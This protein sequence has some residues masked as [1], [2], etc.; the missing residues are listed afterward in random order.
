MLF[1]SVYVRLCPA[2][3]IRTEIY[4]NLVR[5]IVLNHCGVSNAIYYSSCFPQPYGI[6]K[7]SEGSVQID[8]S[9]AAVDFANFNQA[10]QFTVDQQKHRRDVYPWQDE[11]A[12]LNMISHVITVMDKLAGKFSVFLDGLSEWR[13]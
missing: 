4:G 6:R 13:N 9:P 2:A 8:Y 3:Y 12:R 1:A 10:V 7:N 5:M 11:Y